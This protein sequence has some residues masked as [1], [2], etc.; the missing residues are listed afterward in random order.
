M[1]K[2]FITFWKKERD[3]SYLGKQNE[4]PW[5]VHYLLCWISKEYDLKW[6]MALSPLKNKKYEY[7]IFKFKDFYLSCK[8]NFT[9]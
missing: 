1:T 7:N 8:N 2:L 6:L 5:Q 4:T 3:I 9:E